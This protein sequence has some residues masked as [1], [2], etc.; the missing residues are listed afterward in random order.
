MGAG[1]G[2][3]AIDSHG[4]AL[5]PLPA[6]N[7][8]DQ[9][10]ENASRPVSRVLSPPVLR[11]DVRAWPYSSTAILAGDD[12]SSGP[13]LAARFSRP[14]R[15]QPADGPA[16]RQA[17]G[18]CSYSVLLPAGLAVPASLRSRRWALTPPFHHR[19]RP[20]SEGQDAFG[21]LFSVALSLGSLPAGVTRR[22]IRVEPGLSSPPVFRTFKR[23]RPVIR[24]TGGA[25]VRPTG[26]S[27]LGG[28]RLL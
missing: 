23:L 2:E 11:L 6:K 26:A 7:A 5:S 12:H 4:Q 24:N 20:W 25:A 16:P 17:Q 10:Q 9:R 14:T 27:Y 15:A 13:R 8:L 18:A 28:N 22:R 1:C 3:R 19:L 21:R